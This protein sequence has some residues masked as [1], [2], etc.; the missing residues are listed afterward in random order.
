MP[1]A[2]G[3]DRRTKVYRDILDRMPKS[4]VAIEEVFGGEEFHYL[5]EPRCR[6][7]SAGD[8][9]KNL[10]NG[11]QVANLVDALLLYPKSITDVYQTVDPMMADWP[12]KSKI[13]YKSIRTHL[14]KHLSWDRQ[15]MRLMVEKWAEEK[16][17]DVL[18]ARNRMILTQEAWLEATAHFGWNRLI[19][20][21][22]EPS[23]GETQK[24][25][26]QMDE[27]RKQGEGEFSIA[28]LLS[29]FDTLVMVVREFVAPERL[30]EFIER[31]EE[32]ESGI[33]KASLP[34]PEE[35]DVMAEIIA[36]QARFYG[37]DNE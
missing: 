9:R 4:E 22:M 15:A 3:L 24:A 27:L 34:L 29:Q 25:F 16:G 1:E 31:I 17:I 36:E 7:C 5:P 23:W 13:T 32:L 6:V 26:E 30:D 28:T 19:N 20:G 37:G 8:S 11:V 12:P 33:V 2:N 14:N 10:P 21:Q 35:D 18:D